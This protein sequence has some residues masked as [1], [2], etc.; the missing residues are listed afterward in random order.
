M[1]FLNR[2]YITEVIMG[3]VRME[4]SSLDF[5]QEKAD[6]IMNHLAWY[7][8]LTGTEAEL[9]LRDKQDLTYLLREGEKEG[10]YYLTYVKEGC[11][12]TH[13]PFTVHPTLKQWFY[14]QGYPRFATDLKVFVPEIMH[15][16]EAD[17]IP[18]AR[19]VKE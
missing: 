16:E 13:I 17:C 1:R 2:P 19:L 10:N 9:I 5:V 11:S 4:S 3:T 18:L 12:F 14:R 15:A 6:E 8:E 7:G